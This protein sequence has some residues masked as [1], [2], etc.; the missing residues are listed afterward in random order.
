MEDL[1]LSSDFFPKGDN[2]TVKHLL[3]G[4]MLKFIVDKKEGIIVGEQ[5]GIW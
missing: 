4:N 3:E 2:W 1:L 5:E